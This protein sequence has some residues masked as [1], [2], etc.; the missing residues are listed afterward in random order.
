MLVY[1]F[2][3]KIIVKA[4]QLQVQ[5]SIGGKKE[6]KYVIVAFGGGGIGEVVAV[7]QFAEE[8]LAMDALEKAY[9]AFADGAKCYRFD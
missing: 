4:R 3:R 7:A 8:K 1:S 6:A 2:D 9:Q 5:K